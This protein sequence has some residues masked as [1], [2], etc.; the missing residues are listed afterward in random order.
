MGKGPGAAVLRTQITCG[1]G[2][3]GPCGVLRLI[4]M[5]AVY[6]ANVLHWYAITLAPVSYFK[7]ERGLR[8]SLGLW[9]NALHITDLS[10][11]PALPRFTPEF[12]STNRCRPDA[13]GY[14]I[15]TN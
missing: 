15:K 14:I 9:T 13:A 1:R 8:Y 4:P 12:L 5:S 11:L 10:P 7:E 2:F 6:K 3:R